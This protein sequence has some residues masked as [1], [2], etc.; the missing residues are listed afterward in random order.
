VAPA[1]DVTLLLQRQ[2]VVRGPRLRIVN[3]PA[4]N[5]LAVRS[6]GWQNDLTLAPREERVLDLPWANGRRAMVVRLKAST[7]VRPVDLDPQS[8]DRRRLAYWLEVRQ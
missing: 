3:A 1:S 6:D 2:P 5:R 4:A 7:G 8:S